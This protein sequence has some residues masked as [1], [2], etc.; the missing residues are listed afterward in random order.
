VYEKREPGAAPET[1]ADRSDRIIMLAT[2]G[3]LFQGL[4]KALQ[5]H[6]PQADALLLNAVPDAQPSHRVRLV[7]I[8]DSP[9][10]N[11]LSTVD[12]C[13]RRHPSA[14]VGLV[15]E[16]GDGS[17]EGEALFENRMVQGILPLTL[18]LEVWLAAVSLLLSGG[19]YRSVKRNGA[20]TT[21]EAHS[22][23]SPVPVAAL[24]ATMRHGGSIGGLTVREREILELLSEGYQNKIIAHRMQLSEHTVKVHVHNVLAKLRVSNRTQAAAAYRA[25]PAHRAVASVGSGN[26]SGHF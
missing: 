22:I 16:Q 24:E 10:T 2:G 4:L 26:G 6:I 3:A 25:R 21:D 19:E 5:L 15:A 20:P 9:G 23:L 13:R 12:I 8:N 7:L 11:L 14:V 1:L 18:N 17:A